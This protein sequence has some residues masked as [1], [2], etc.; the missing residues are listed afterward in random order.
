MIPAFGII[1]IIT[2]RILQ[3]IIF[4]QQSMTFAKSSISLLGS[5]VW[6]HHMY[7]VGL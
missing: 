4:A 2:S 5:L 3:L 1:S 7:T 6:G